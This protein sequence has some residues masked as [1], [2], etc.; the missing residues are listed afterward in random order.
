M[1]RKITALLLACLMTISCFSAVL[2]EPT[3]G[4]VYDNWSG[5]TD[6]E[7]YALALEEKGELTVYATSSKM[8]KAEKGFEELYP[9][10]DLV[11]YDLDQDEVLSKL[12]DIAVKSAGFCRCKTYA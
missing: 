8:L 7:L 1:K 3:Y 9:G 6:E 5:M 11:I 2:A 4:P 12:F 10:I